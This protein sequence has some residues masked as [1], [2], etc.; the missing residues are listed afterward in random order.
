MCCTKILGLD[1]FLKSRNCNLH[2]LVHT[3]FLKFRCEYKIK[4]HPGIFTE[5]NVAEVY[6]FERRHYSP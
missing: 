4:R 5:K 3:V 2:L 1:Y 6:P